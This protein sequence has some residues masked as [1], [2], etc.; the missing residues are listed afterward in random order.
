MS[1]FIKR[2]DVIHLVVRKCLKQKGWTLIAGEYP[3]GSDDELNSLRIMDSK[4]AKDD[5]PD[6][7]R[8]SINKL[9]PDLVTYKDSEFLIIEMKPKYD[10]GDE[11]KLKELL[12]DRKTD[13]KEYLSM[14]IGRYFPNKNI[15]V[16]N[17]ILT[18]CLGF[19][20]GEYPKTLGFTYI[21]VNSMESITIDRN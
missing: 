9:I 20:N 11:D 1:A 13:L 18:P 19:A 5:S 8:H 17:C 12:F 10:K 15:Q 2:E 3:N 6:H 7:R 4:F 14:F 16:D 21:L